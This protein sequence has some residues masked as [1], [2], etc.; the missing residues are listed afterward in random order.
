MDLDYQSM[1][2]WVIE[3]IIDGVKLMLDHLSEILVLSKSMVELPLTSIDQ[4]FTYQI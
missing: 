3:N 2:E 4:D 1:Q